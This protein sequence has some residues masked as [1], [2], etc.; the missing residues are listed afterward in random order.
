MDD[1]FS[2]LNDIEFDTANLWRE[3]VYTDRK[4]GSI[5][6]QIPVTADGLDDPMR[7]TEY[8]VQSTIMTGGGALPVEGRVEGAK[9]L[10]EAAAQFGPATKQAVED[11]IQQAQ[12]M[13]REAANQIVTP[14]QLGGGG[15]LGGGLAGGGG[16]P[17][18]GGFSLR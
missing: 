3:E 6:V 4:T 12:E 5:R 9:S 11:M 14:D 16:A 1:R 15:G 7:E 8:Y 10:A 2:Q 18:G 17:A 13:Q